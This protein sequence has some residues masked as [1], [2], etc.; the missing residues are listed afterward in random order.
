VSQKSGK[1]YFSG[2]LTL[3]SKGLIFEN[4]DRQT[5]KDPIYILYLVERELRTTTAK[6]KML[7]RIRVGRGGESILGE[8]V[9]ALPRKPH[10]KGG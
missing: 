5:D 8:R 10:Q 7:F 4:P 6:R 2:I 9:L 3:L 1:G